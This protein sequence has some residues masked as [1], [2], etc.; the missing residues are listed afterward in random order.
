MTE[1]QWDRVINI[2]LKG[3]FNCI[4]GV[5]EQMIAQGSGVI[6]NISSVVALYGNVGHRINAATK[7][8]LIGITKT[9][10]K[11][12]GRKGIRVM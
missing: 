12:L 4:Q 5:V 11:E 8:G 1:E 6:I 7:S 2:N 10:G 3:P 9:L